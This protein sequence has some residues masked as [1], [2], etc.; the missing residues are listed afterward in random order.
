MKT[1]HRFNLLKSQ[2]SK[3]IYNKILDAVKSFEPNISIS[4]LKPKEA[5]QIYYDVYRDYPELFY[6]PSEIGYRATFFETTLQFNYIY[7]NSEIVKRSN[8]INKCLAEIN[9]LVSNIF[10]DFKKVNVVIEYIAKKTSYAIDCKYNQNASAVFC[11]NVAQCSGYSKALQLALE[12]I[13]IPVI[14]VEGKSQNQNHAWNIVKINNKYYHVDVT[15]L[16]GINNNSNDLRIKQYLFYTDDMMKADHSWDNK[17]FPVCDDNSLNNKL[18]SINNQNDNSVKIFNNLN[19]LRL[20]IIDS[21]N[22]RLP[23]IEFIMQLNN[24]S[25]AEINRYFQNTLKRAIN[26][27]KVSVKISYSIGEY[28]QIKFE[29]L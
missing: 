26:E 7:S 22:K 16:D 24:F 12:S 14:Y 21:L 28:C 23:M 10:D 6:L 9:S 4:L 20:Y 19:D 5:V 27:A 2:N 18:R 1:N 11:D 17:S 8:I 3:N 15:Y 13:N 29:Y 25:Q